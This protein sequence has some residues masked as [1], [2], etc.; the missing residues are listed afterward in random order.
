VAAGGVDR[1]EPPPSPLIGSVGG[2]VVA[3]YT[4][5]GDQYGFPMDTD[6]VSRHCLGAEEGRSGSPIA[7]YLDPASGAPVYRQLVQQVERALLRGYLREGDQLPL[8][9]EV[10]TSLAVN[11]DTV[12]KAYRE[13]E[14]RGIAVGRRGRGTFVTAA[15]ALPNVREIAGLRS[16]LL[17]WLSDARTAGLTDDMAAA[18]FSAVL[19]DHAGGP[20]APAASQPESDEVAAEGIA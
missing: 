10:T 8:I 11:P 4:R 19:R 6:K 17:G 16:R 1:Y 14:T 3:L 12:Q 13:L 7:F 20:G 5:P 15:P 2:S 9:R 18:L